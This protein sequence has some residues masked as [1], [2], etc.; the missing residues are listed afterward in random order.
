MKRP[1]GFDP[2]A[3]HVDY[4]S[5]V[6]A[7]AVGPRTLLECQ[8]CLDDDPDAEAGFLVLRIDAA[9]ATR[10]MLNHL[11][12]RHDILPSRPLRPSPGD[13]HDRPRPPRPDP[14]R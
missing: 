2:R 5:P 9:E 6:R 12:Q 14:R 8:R 7:F 13:R 3:V 10:R 4:V 11:A 1:D